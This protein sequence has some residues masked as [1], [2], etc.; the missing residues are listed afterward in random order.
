MEFRLVG[1]LLCSGGGAEDAG[2][3]TPRNSTDTFCTFKLPRAFLKAARGDPEA[4]A[5]WSYSA[6]SCS[7]GHG[8]L[9]S[10]SLVHVR[11]TGSDDTFCTVTWEVSGSPKNRARRCTVLIC[12]SMLFA[13]SQFLGLSVT[14]NLWWTARAL[15]CCQ[16]LMS[17]RSCTVSPSLSMASRRNWYLPMCS[18][19][20]S[21]DSVCF[22]AS[23]WIHERGSIAV[24]ADVKNISLSSRV[25]PCS[26]SWKASAGI[27]KVQTLPAVALSFGSRLFSVGLVLPPAGFLGVSGVGSA[28]V[29]D[30][31]G[32]TLVGCTSSGPNVGV[33]SPNAPSTNEV[34]VGRSGGSTGVIP[35]AAVG[36]TTDDRVGDAA[37][38]RAWWSSPWW[39]LCGWC[40]VGP[41]KTGDAIVGTILV[42]GVAI[43]RSP[44]MLPVSVATTVG[45]GAGT[46]GV[47]PM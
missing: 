27:W 16:T 6:I 26:R 46:N 4:S 24:P 32:P 28:G 40:T 23:N 17:I 44:T 36:S 29:A 22:S 12:Q 8:C 39:C 10:E 47:P 2:G 11:L 20:G 37:M 35:S 14:R 41:S 3:Q 43:G 5:I 7:R 21:A 30:T 13:Y 9:G 31:S 33:T 1:A 18:S 42:S 34:C 25:S 38:W 15:E 45:S 19:R